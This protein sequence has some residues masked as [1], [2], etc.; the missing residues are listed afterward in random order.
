MLHFNAAGPA[1]KSAASEEDVYKVLILDRHTKVG[2]G[3]MESAAW[4]RRA[5]QV[6]CAPYR[7][8]RSSAAP[9]RPPPHFNPPL[10]RPLQTATHAPPQDILAPLLHVNELRKHGVTLHMLLDAERQPIPD[11]PAIY[12]VQPSE[13]AVARIVQDVARGLYDAFHLNFSTHIPRPLMEKLA[14]GTRVAEGHRQLLA[15]LT[16]PLCQRPAS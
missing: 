10:H 8:V 13:A 16:L 11:V 4:Q 1:V 15:V 7:T 12:F 3:W 14:A 2:V 6:G 5:L 9:A